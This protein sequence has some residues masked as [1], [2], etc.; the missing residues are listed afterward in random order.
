M[1]GLTLPRVIRSE[2]I[3]VRSVRSTVGV[4]Y[5]PGPFRVVSAAYRLQRNYSE[6]I[7]IG[8]QW[9]LNDTLTER[10]IANLGRYEGAVEAV[11][12]QGACSDTMES[13]GRYMMHNNY[14]YSLALLDW[15]TATATPFIYASSAATYGDG[16][17][18]F[19]DDWEPSA[20][21]RL[22]PERVERARVTLGVDDP[23]DDL[24]LGGAAHMMSPD[25]RGDSRAC[26]P[27]SSR[28]LA[29]GLPLA[30]L[31]AGEM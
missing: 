24:A 12:H 4:R 2:W 27:F 19:S 25:R 28:Y 1:L 15:C 8:W 21:R 18:G 17:E 30:M 5:H 6:Q 7:D 10:F 20:L 23:V 31:P 13:D 9:P 29:A 26:T 11:F 16:N 14:E 3:K 22:L